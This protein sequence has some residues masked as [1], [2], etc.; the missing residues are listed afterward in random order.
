MRI[1]IFTQIFL[2][3]PIYIF[4]SGAAFSRIIPLLWTSNVGW[5]I[6]KTDI[7]KMRGKIRDIRAKTTP[8]QKKTKIKIFYPQKWV[9]LSSLRIVSFKSI[10]T[11]WRT[12][13]NQLFNFW[14]P[15]KIAFENTECITYLDYFLQNVG[16]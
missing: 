5:T 7:K 9:P 4:I 13:N 11:M 12:L 15:W 16:V 6:S 3:C 10:E 1:V 14:C 2:P 8:K